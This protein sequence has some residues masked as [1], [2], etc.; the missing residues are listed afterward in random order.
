MSLALPT[1][2]VQKRKDEKG[3]QNNVLQNSSHLPQ[4]L[5]KIPFEPH[6]ETCTSKASEHML[7][8]CPA[9]LVHS[10]CNFINTV[11]CRCQRTST[12]ECWDLCASGREAASQTTQR[13]SQIER[14]PET[15]PGTADSSKIFDGANNL[16]N[17]EMRAE[18]KA[19]CRS[20]HED[21]YS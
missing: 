3:K 16:K 14:L 13:R 21:A 6:E 4:G 10:Y 15:T 12:T 2:G 8:D 9:M 19:R 1:H 20:L 5:L 7:G 17:N 18:A 11:A